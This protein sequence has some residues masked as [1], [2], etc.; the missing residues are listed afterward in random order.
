MPE[1]CP[2]FGSLWRSRFFVLWEAGAPWPGTTAAT[3]FEA[4]CCVDPGTAMTGIY[5][6]FWGH[7]AVFRPVLDARS[8]R[9]AGSV[10]QKAKPPAFGVDLLQEFMQGCLRLRGQAKAIDMATLMPLGS[11]VQN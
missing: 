9:R 4:G 6:A 10:N 11:G 2:I 7:R 5:D 3:G 1:A 8:A